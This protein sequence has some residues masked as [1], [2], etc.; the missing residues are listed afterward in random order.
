MAINQDMKDIVPG[1]KLRYGFLF[2]ALEALRDNLFKKVRRPGHG[3]AT[4]KGHKIASLD[5]SLPDTKTQKERKTASLPADI[6]L[7]DFTPRLIA[8][9][10]LY[11]STLNDSMTPES[12]CY[13]PLDKP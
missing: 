11:W 7:H 12:I 8:L 9:S 10:D 3:T 4:L 5:I 1:P 13:A 6:K 2:Y